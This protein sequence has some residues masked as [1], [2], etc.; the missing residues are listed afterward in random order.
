M[1]NPGGDDQTSLVSLSFSSLEN[2][3]D[4][5]VKGEEEGNELLP[6]KDRRSSLTRHHRQLQYLR[7][8][9]GW[10]RHKLE[11]EKKVRT[12]RTVEEVEKKQGSLT[13][14]NVNGISRKLLRPGGVVEPLVVAGRTKLEKTRSDLISTSRRKLFFPPHPD[15][16]GPLPPSPSRASQHILNISK[17][18]VELTLELKG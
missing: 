16:T 1:S 11:R 14:S 4:R 15:A 9:C 6:G 10:Q 3:S 5:A 8:K 7:C 17:R 2:G 18:E 12:R 13:R